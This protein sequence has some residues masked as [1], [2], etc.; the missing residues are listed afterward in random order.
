MYQQGKDYFFYASHQALD[1][2]KTCLLAGDTA[3][4]IM[5]E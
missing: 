5:T 4:L 3:A 2:V 1:V